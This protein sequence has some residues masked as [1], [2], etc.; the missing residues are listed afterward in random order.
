MT[1]SKTKLYF[2]DHAATK[3]RL[4]S[5]SKLVLLPLLVLLQSCATNP[6]TGKSE[7]SLYSVNQQIALGTQ[8]YGPSIQS[9]G[10]HYAIDPPLTEYVRSVGE[11]LV[12]VLPQVSPTAPELP[13]EFVV[14]NN[15]VPNAWA[16]PG[17]KMAINRG[18]LV[19]LENEAE[20][21]AVLGHEIIHAVAAHGTNR[22]SLGGLLSAGSQA[23]G[24]L[25]QNESY[26]QI[27]QIGTSI[28]ANAWLAKYGRSDELESDYYGM[29]LM[30]A[31]GYSPSGAVTLQEK[32]VALS[33]G[34][35]SDWISGLFA[36]H[37]PSQERVEKNLEL[38]GQ[39]PSGELGKGSYQ[40]KLAPL[41]KQQPAYELEQ[42]AIAALQNDAPRQALSLLDEAIKI[43]P[44]QDQ[45]WVL[46]GYAWLHKDIDNPDNASKA[47]STAISKNPDYFKPWLLR[48]QLNWKQQQYSAAEDDLKRS[49]SL[50]PTA[51]SAYY[52]GDIAERNNQP[53]QAIEYYQQA[54]QGSGEASQSAQYALARIDFDQNPQR[55]IGAK[56]LVDAYGALNIKVSNLSPFSVNNIGV[57]LVDK[58]TGLSKK[59]SIDA[60]STKQAQVIN[61]LI[62]DA[63][64]HYGVQVVKANRLPQ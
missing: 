7:L 36:S 56:L 64:E 49:Q 53:Q 63:P 17:G 10:G 15:S 21:A 48:G 54:A 47:F 5:L 29:Q 30:S 1:F 2:A 51:D 52:L 8:Q 26:G 25:T 27:A 40:A 46:R 31:A 11:R 4:V 42:K 28:G 22:S 61:T 18:L 57:L 39:L 50:L 9:Q 37:P 13:F 58:R 20:L 60:L 19:A 44:K 3:Q 23:V 43:T 32:F 41:Q 62:K 12:A 34:R 45:F 59:L 35:K 16:L 14:L 33:Q 6:L 38:A 55:Y 24:L